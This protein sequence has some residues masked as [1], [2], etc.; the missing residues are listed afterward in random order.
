MIAVTVFGLII[1]G[2]GA[3]LFFLFYQN[4]NHGQYFRKRNVPYIGAGYCRFF[5]F[6]MGQI[7]I[8][9]TEEL[10]Y[11]DA[12]K[13]KSPI[14][15]FSD[16]FSVPSYFATDLKLIRNIYVKD[17]DHFVDR[18]NISGLTGNGKNNFL[19]KMIVSM[20][21]EE[22][23]EMRSK[24]SPTFTTGKLRR[25]FT[26][27]NS[28]SHRM[29]QYI[30]TILGPSGKEFDV[31]EAYSKYAMD[32]IASCAFGVDSKSFEC[33]PGTKSEFEKMGHKLQFNAKFFMRFI[34]VLLAPN[35]ARRLGIQV[36]KAE[37]QLYFRNVIMKVLEHRRK[38]GARQDDFLQLMMDAQEGL[39]KNEE[40]SKETMEVMTG[41]DGGDSKPLISEEVHSL[42]F[43]DDTIVANSVL[44]FIAGYD[45][46]QSLLI[47]ATY[48][49][50]VDQ[51]IQEKLLKEVSTALESHDGT[52]DYDAV[53]QMNYLDLF[54]QGIRIRY[55]F[56]F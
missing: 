8:S 30:N 4:W 16:S 7:P 14:V 17:F 52:L 5:R 46:L 24:L 51:D 53:S 18:R 21:A 55:K 38:T 36:V 6:L 20:T 27:F 22:W 9:E 32:V 44:F 41:T 1:L 10:M 34:F 15:G 23:K 26:I 11:K 43:D 42:V 29:C 45:T 13:T 39:L 47:Y 35:L 54:V 31:C 56:N 19:H 25:M 28:S 12:I 2:I 3:L 48:Q 49:L 40:N 50:A 37:P 33:A